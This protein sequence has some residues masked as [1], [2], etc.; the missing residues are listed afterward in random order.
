ME[1]KWT[2][3]A[4]VTTTKKW[5]TTYHLL[6]FLIGKTTRLVYIIGDVLILIQGLTFSILPFTSTYILHFTLQANAVRG[7]IASVCCAVFFI[8]VGL[9]YKF[10][11]KSFRDEDEDEQGQETNGES[12]SEVV[13]TKYIY[14]IIFFAF[15]L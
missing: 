1:Y 12:A 8:L 5:E 13:C 6:R 15:F 4:L 7:V 9:V 14:H 3:T 11:W 2:G 10:R